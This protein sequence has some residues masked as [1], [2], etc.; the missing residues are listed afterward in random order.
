M[1]IHYGIFSLLFAVTELKNFNGDAMHA[2]IRG[3]TDSCIGGF[4][5]QS[6]IFV[7]FH[8]FYVFVF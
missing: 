1:A 5:K 2:I 4:A 7:G 6:K 8:A 3:S